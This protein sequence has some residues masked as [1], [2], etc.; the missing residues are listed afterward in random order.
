MHQFQDLCERC[1][2]DVRHTLEHLASIPP[3]NLP[4]SGLRDSLLIIERDYLLSEALLLPLKNCIISF[5]NEMFFSPPT[6]PNGSILNEQIIPFIDKYI[7]P[8]LVAV[9][10]GSLT[11]AWNLAYYSILFHLLDYRYLQ[12]YFYSKG[13]QIF[14]G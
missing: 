8:W 2:H 3:A 6:P 11:R 12:D 7:N 9:D 4:L 13:Y 14:I 1:V 5:F 10:H